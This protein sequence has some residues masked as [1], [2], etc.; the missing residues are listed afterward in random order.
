MAYTDSKLADDTDASDEMAFGAGGA[1]MQALEQS[2]PSLKTVAK[3]KAKAVAAKKKV[4]VPKKKPGQSL[5]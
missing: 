2:N 1:I 5:T 4:A 3:P